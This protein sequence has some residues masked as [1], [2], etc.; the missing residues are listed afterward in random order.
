[1]PKR[2]FDKF[3]TIEDWDSFVRFFEWLPLWGQIVTGA[4]IFGLFLIVYI[5]I[6]GIF[7]DKQL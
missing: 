4:V 7:T 6:V 2:F 1:M 5:F 3:S